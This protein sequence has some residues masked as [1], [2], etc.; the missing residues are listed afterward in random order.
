MVGEIRGGFDKL[1]GAD[2][3]VL[4]GGRY[5]RVKRGPSLGFTRIS[6][7]AIE[8]VL[9]KEKQGILI[10]LNQVQENQTK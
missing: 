2:Y 10:E 4:V 9:K 1:E 7:K 6:L 8:R 5:S 3:E